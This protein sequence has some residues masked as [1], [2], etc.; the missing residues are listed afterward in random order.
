M[1]LH[2]LPLLWAALA[3]TDD[4]ASRGQAVFCGGET[5]VATVE[6]YFSE[7]DR[8]LTNPVVYRPRFNG[9]VGDRFGIRDARGRT[10][11][12]NVSEVGL[13]SPGRISIEE[14]REISRRGARGLR[15]AGWRGCFMDHGKV[16]FESGQDGSFR[17]ILIAR[18]IPWVELSSGNALP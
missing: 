14:W 3:T 12:F 8:A 15:N 9:F 7:L 11:Y 5:N 4:S 1:F 6:N 13:V 2:V 16:W 17:L 10:L 18:D